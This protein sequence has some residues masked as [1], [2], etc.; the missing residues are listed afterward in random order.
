MLKQLPMLKL[1]ILQLGA[2]AYAAANV[3]AAA[4]AQCTID[5]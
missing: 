3:H 2:N 5:S 4:D 1:S